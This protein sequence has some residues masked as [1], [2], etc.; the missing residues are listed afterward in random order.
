MANEVMEP[1]TKRRRIS[2]S[3]LEWQRRLK[4][5]CKYAGVN[6]NYATSV[7]ITHKVGGY[8]EISVEYIGT[9]LT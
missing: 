4:E 2:P 1:E 7:T 5:L 8:V 3:D 9:S 6:I